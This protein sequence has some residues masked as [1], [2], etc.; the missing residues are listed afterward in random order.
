MNILLGTF[1]TPFETT[2]FDQIKQDDFLPALKESIALAH[3]RVAEIKKNKD[4]ETFSNVI[5][6][7][8]ASDPEVSRVAEIF[9]N[10]HSAETNDELQNIAKE[11]SPMLTAY[12][13][14][15]ALDN[16]LFLKIKKVWDKRSALSLSKE[17]SMLLEK[18]YK[19][20]VRN[21]ALLN[22]EGK[23]R[24]RE[25][26]EK[27]STLSLKFSDNVLKETNEYVLWADKIEDLKGLPEDAVNEAAELASKKNAPGKWAFTLHFPSLFPFLTYAE[28]RSLRKELF[29]ANAKRG[30][31]A[32][33]TDNREIVKEIAKLRH[34]K[35]ALLGYPSHAHFTL[36]ER[37][38]SDPKTVTN[39][40]EDIVQHALPAA[41][42]ETEELKAYAKSLDGIEVLEKWDLSFY[43]EKLK[44]EKFKV[45][46]EMLRPYFQLDKVISGVF[47]VAEN[48][49]GLQF[50]ERKDIP[51]YHED[52]KTYEVLDKN[53]MHKAIF[54]ADFH[55]RAGKRSGAW[56]TSY[57]EQKIVNGENIRP[58]IAIV[59]NFTK[60]QPS[61]PSLLTF[62]EVT[63]LFHEFG[64]ALHGIMANTKYKTL[65]GVNVYWDFVEL[66]SQIL[67]NW[68]YEKE[69]LD[70]FAEHFE[71][72]EKIPESLIKKIK[73]SSNFL[74]GRATLRQMSFATIDMGWHKADPSAVTDIEAFEK[75]LSG[76]M[77]FLPPIADSSISSAFSHIF[78]GGYSSG[79]YSYKWAEV[80]DADAFEFFKEKGIFNSEVAERFQESILSKGASE[81]PMD[82]YVSFRGKKPDPEA[83]LRRAGLLG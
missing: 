79:Y 33:E 54:Y 50:K 82:L 40:I 55:P 41:K 43:G 70:L 60:P 80:L 53:G 47:K 56:M 5:E 12:S 58:H 67:E 69:C 8:E 3:S 23:K 71:T 27:L 49:Y 15:I 77:D 63:T 7:L 34:E 20:F 1:K 11:F 68:A 39:F 74:E 72:G 66:P 81:H 83:L 64:H 36:E 57:R 24:L 21:G 30:Y 75:S 37:M 65:S 73:E 19:S 2:P 25:I 10:L 52:V 13:N 32:G 14:D 61:R 78:S 44:H 28:N 62:N 26:T 31:K 17:E 29:L 22:D 46:D 76:H 4:P 45:N 6:A 35:A 48:L 16:E 42:K 51:V 59:C 18:T 9:F 38:A